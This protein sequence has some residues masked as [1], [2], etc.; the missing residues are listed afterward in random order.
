MHTRVCEYGFDRLRLSV[1]RS[2]GGWVRDNPMSKYNHRI[3]L[4]EASDAEE[5][6]IVGTVQKDCISSLVQC[7]PTIF[8]R[9]G[10]VRVPVE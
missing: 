10:R 3:I 9:F 8:V 6:N 5:E 2:L 7:R 1:E 4:R